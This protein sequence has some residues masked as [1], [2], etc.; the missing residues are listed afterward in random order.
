M[1]AIIVLLYTVVMKKNWMQLKRGLKV[2]LLA[3]TH[4]E[5]NELGER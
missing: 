4:C 2:A 3:K 1:T 5:Y